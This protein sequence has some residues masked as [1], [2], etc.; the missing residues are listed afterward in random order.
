M[1]QSLPEV[2]DQRALLVHNGQCAHVRSSHLAEG[3]DRDL[4]RPRHTHGLAAI[5]SLWR[6]RGGQDKPGI[7]MH[8]MEEQQ[9]QQQQQQQKQQ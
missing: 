1:A 6:V 5:A 9:Q 2:A 4:T 7:L 3:V 8:T